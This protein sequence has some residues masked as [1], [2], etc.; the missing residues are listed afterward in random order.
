MSPSFRDVAH[1]DGEQLGQVMR[2]LTAEAARLD[3]AVARRLGV[4]P[5]DLMAL[6]ELDR[7]AGLTPSRL[8]QR[9]GLTSG[10]LTALADRLERHGLLERVPHPHDRRSTLLRLTD[11]ANG[12]ARQAYG[13]LA[14]EATEHFASYSAPERATILRYL[15]EAAALTAAHA[16]RQAA[17]SRAPRRA[18]PRSSPGDGS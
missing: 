13:D 16:E 12:F 1:A 4:S 10:A 8:A 2:H 14:A 17:L 9:L 3:A 6:D 15:G 7:T 11:R 18:R 5:V